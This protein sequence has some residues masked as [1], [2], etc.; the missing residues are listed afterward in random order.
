MHTVNRDIRANPENMQYPHKLVCRYLPA[1]SVSISCKRSLESLQSSH[2]LAREIKSLVYIRMQ[3]KTNIM[4]VNKTVTA[5]AVLAVDSGLTKFCSTPGGGRCEATWERSMP[6][7][8][9]AKFAMMIAGRRMASSLEYSKGVGKI[10]RCSALYS[11]DKQLQQ[12]Q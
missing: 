8:R 10:L 4:T 5:I 12:G 3:T 1:Y 11:L 7:G 9:F 6:G 2:P